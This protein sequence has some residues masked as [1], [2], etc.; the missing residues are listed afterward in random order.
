MSAEFARRAAAGD[1]SPEIIAW[2]QRSCA[3]YEAG[4][5]LEVA[6]ELDRAARIRQMRAA[7][8]DAAR[9]LA[10]ED[11]AWHC[12]ERLEGAIRRYQARV[13]PLIERDQA[14]SL[15]PL[16]QALRRA[17]ATRQRVPT[18]QRNLYELIR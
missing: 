16:D 9:L 3:R 1:T 8:Q 15:P 5:P 4:E 11:G 12:A 10:A 18:T 7:L 17:F 6:F 13:A 2:Q 14:M